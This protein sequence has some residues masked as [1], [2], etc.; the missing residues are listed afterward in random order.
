MISRVM[1]QLTTMVT[2]FASLLLLGTFSIAKGSQQAIFYIEPYWLIS[3]DELKVHILTPTQSMTLVLSPITDPASALYFKEFT[4]ERHPGLLITEWE[5]N[6]VLVTIKTSQDWQPGLYEVILASVGLEPKRGYFVLSPT[7]PGRDAITAVVVD[8]IQYQVDNPYGGANMYLPADSPF[9]RTNRTP[10]YKPYAATTHQE[11]V[12]LIKWLEMLNIPFEVLSIMD[13]HSR[14]DAIGDYATIVF[15]GPSN[16]WTRNIYDSLESFVLGGG[17]LV[18][19]SGTAG[20]YQ[21]RFEG[22]PPQLVC[23]KSF[24]DPI[25]FMD[26]SLT[27]TEWRSPVLQ[28]EELFLLGAMVDQRARGPAKTDFYIFNPHHWAFWR[29]Y[30]WFGDKFLA[31][32]MLVSF[33]HRHAEKLEE[34]DFNK[35]INRP[36]IYRLAN[37]D[38]N[39]WNSK[40][41]EAEMNVW[42]PYKDSD[43]IVFIS[44]LEN[45]ANQLR[46]SD[47]NSLGSLFSHI[48][49]NI[50]QNLSERQ[51]PDAF[52]DTLKKCMESRIA[53]TILG[54]GAYQ[55]L[56]TKEFGGALFLGL[57]IRGHPIS[58]D[59]I[60]LA[61]FDHP[62]SLDINDSGKDG[63]LIPGDGFY[64]CIKA[65]PPSD[66]AG[67]YLVSA[68]MLG[69]SGYEIFPYLEIPERLDHPLL[70][71]E[72]FRQGFEKHLITPA[73]ESKK[74]IKD[75]IDLKTPLQVSYE[76]LLPYPQID[77][78]FADKHYEAFH[79]K[80]TILAAGTAGTRVSQASGGILF[81]Q[82]A[83]FDP[84]G[85]NDIID[86]R[87]YY[88]DEVVCRLN[89]LGEYGD[90]LPGD[91]VFSRAVKILPKV[92]VGHYLFTIKAFDDAEL[93]SDPWPYICIH[94]GT[95]LDPFP[96]NKRNGNRFSG[97]EI[98]SNL[99]LRRELTPEFYKRSI[100]A[101]SL[102]FV[103]IFSAT[104]YLFYLLYRDRQLQDR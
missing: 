46:I 74:R 17:N 24:D 33:C 97:W 69:N 82:C 6:Q 43:G 102:L 70:S 53:P 66:K 15:P 65:I 61:Y 81:F 49:Y 63:D 58:Q 31:D 67:T 16:Y 22:D 34:V 1:Q 9:R 30:L 48:T 59:D 72:Q 96:Q 28:R 50:L 55:S 51:I 68:Y 57:Q 92:P 23:Y 90:L 52:E 7:D 60:K 18:L 62:L 78:G 8:D 75:Y 89:D 25:T 76:H 71:A 21:V 64:S 32:D 95:K 80:P 73:F 35:S 104:C 27:T 88:Q 4:R 41:I 79:G 98:S 11:V 103:S 100:R 39:S 14:G 10:F 101:I 99:R 40:G 19:L 56:I 26:P 83:V 84:Q 13:L 12:A 3:G 54:G 29:C 93:I 5:D 91:G 94:A 20:R 38:P 47:Y 87:V 37:N 85:S 44:G 86:V 2:I 42:R 77:L 36:E 45:W